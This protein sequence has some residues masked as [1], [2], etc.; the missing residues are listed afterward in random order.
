LAARMV[1]DLKEGV[2]LARDAITSGRAAK[3]LQQLQEMSEITHS[4]S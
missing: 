3:I 1:A 2:R 4:G